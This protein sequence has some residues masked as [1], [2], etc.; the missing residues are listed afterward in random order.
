[1]TGKEMKYSS[2]Q[3][4]KE[5]ELK[6]TETKAVDFV[7]GFLTHSYGVNSGDSSIVLKSINNTVISP[8]D[9]LP[10]YST[11]QPTFEKVICQYN[12]AL[13]QASPDC[14]PCLIGNCSGFCW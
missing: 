11:L 6:N 5:T 13:L 8:L 14:R 4:Q 2:Q 3:L 10:I 1:M 9:F 12:N 7:L